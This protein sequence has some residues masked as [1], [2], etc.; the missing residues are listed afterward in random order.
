MNE[1]ITGADQAVI[2]LTQNMGELEPSLAV[3]SIAELSQLENHIRAQGHDLAYILTPAGQEAYA[4]TPNA[5]QIN[6]LL[7]RSFTVGMKA[8]EWSDHGVTALCRTSQR[9]PQ[10][11]LER[12]GQDAPPVLY[13]AGPAEAIGN[14]QIAVSLPWETGADFHKYATQLGQ[15]IQKLGSVF[16]TGADSYHERCLVS[17]G[18]SQNSAAVGI[19]RT[20]LLAAAKDRAYR[21]HFNRGRLL[22]V[23]AQSPEY[24]GVPAQED[25]TTAQALIHTLAGRTMVVHEGPPP[26][27]RWSDLTPETPPEPQ[28]PE[29]V[30]AGKIYSRPGR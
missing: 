20:G 19:A 29:S 25:H 1:H 2:L 30:L 14:V 4:G 12:M 28:Q 13:C 11:V 16:A 24:E 3:L 17:A 23:S 21:Q 27:W 26:G 9:Y 8:K 22:L 15:G 6:R 7:S 10:R 5:A 18:A